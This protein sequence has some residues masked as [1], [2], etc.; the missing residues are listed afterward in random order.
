MLYLGLDIEFPMVFEGKAWEMGKR[1]AA[2]KKVGE[3]ENCTIAK[4]ASQGLSDIR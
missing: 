1:K 4:T 2:N 3:A